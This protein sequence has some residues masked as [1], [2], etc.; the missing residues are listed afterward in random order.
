MI[1]YNLIFNLMK[2]DLYN[3]LE[4]DYVQSM[5]LIGSLIGQFAFQ[6]HGD[7]LLFRPEGT[8][9]PGA[10]EEDLPMRVKCKP[11]PIH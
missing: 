6:S 8:Q 3:S 1:P 7:R 9:P 10:Q 5:S 4:A 11:T 2:Q